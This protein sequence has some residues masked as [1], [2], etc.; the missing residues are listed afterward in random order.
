MIFWD[1]P[2]YFFLLLFIPVLLWLFLQLSLWRKKVRDQYADS[3]LQDDVFKNR[4]RSWFNLK[5]IWLLLAVFSLIL[6][7]IGPQ[8]GEEEQKLKREGID[9]VFALDLSHS[10]N[11]EDISPSRLEKAK[12]FM[13]TYIETLGGDRA[14]LVIFAGEAYSVSPLTSDYAALNSYIE[15]LDTNL[16]WNQGT[17]IASALEESITVLGESRDVSKAV[18]LISDGEDHEEG[19]SDVLENMKDRGIEV[20]AVGVGNNVPVPIPMRTPDGWDDGFKLDDNGSTVLTSFNGA[21]LRSV[22]EKSGG[23]YIKLERTQDA[24]N[25][26]RS[27]INTLEKK[28]QSEMTGFNRKHQYQWFLGLGILFF[29][30]YSLT[31]ENKKIKR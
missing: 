28:A 2:Y 7:I 15:S 23:S 10:M 12:N 9:I 6:A 22:A 8:W 20:F 27:G 3:M 19:I 30:I 26:L 21:A 24:V 17:H 16:L 1:K 13:S 31:P 11:A 4:P 18:V 29:F 14:G 25:D 5:L